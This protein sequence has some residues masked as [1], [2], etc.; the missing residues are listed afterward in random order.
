TGR[1]HVLGP[2]VREIAKT[3]CDPSGPRGE[4]VP[5]HFEL[6]RA[7]GGL[8]R[9]IGRASCRGGGRVRDGEVVFGGGDALGAW[10]DDLDATEGIYSP[11][12]RDYVV[13]ACDLTGRYHVLDPTVREIAKTNCDTSGPRGEVVPMHFEL[14]RAVGGLGR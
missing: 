4:V 10:I 8:G 3:N 6:L 12:D 2:T 11:D 5:M 7:V 13:F 1:Y 9:E 14:L